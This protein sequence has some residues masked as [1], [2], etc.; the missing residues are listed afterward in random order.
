[1]V[2]IIF[3]GTGGGRLNLIR[4]VR[5][6]GGFIIRGGE[7][8]GVQIHVDPGPGALVRAYQYKCDPTK[9]DVII[10]THAHLDHCAD[11]EVL[12]E[13]MSVPKQRAHGLL[14]GSR[15]AIAGS[16]RRAIPEGDSIHGN[17]RFEPI[18]S[19]YFRKKAERVEALGWGESRKLPGNAQ[20]HGVKALHE[21]DSCFGFVLELDCRRIGYTS[22]TQ[23]LREHETEYRGVDCLILNCLKP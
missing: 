7:G 8:S 4:Q 14:L 19:E 5:A 2:K 18:I 15:N 6:T 9:T 1:M 20:I 13:A 10:V 11:V 17:G 12:L 3:L 23:Y 21:E 16:S 22:D